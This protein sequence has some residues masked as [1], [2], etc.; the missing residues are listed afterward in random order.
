MA[1]MVMF[2]VIAVNIWPSVQPVVGDIMSNILSPGSPFVVVLNYATSLNVAKVM[3][4]VAFVV[5]FTCLL[6]QYFLRNNDIQ[7]D[8]KFKLT[9]NKCYFWIMGTAIYW[10]MIITFRS[11]VAGDFESNFFMGM[12]AAAVS[13]FALVFGSIWGELTAKKYQR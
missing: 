8:Q 5:G 7:A 10:S 1:T 11:A 3:S 12:M 2:G 6:M 13:F 9:I 4:V